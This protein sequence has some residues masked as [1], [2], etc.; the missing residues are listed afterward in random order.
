M[1]PARPPK[2]RQCGVQQ[3]TE[4]LY[5]LDPNLRGRHQRIEDECRRSIAKGEHDQDVSG[6]LVMESK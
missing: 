5:E 6:V 1:S 3:V 4:R 2:H